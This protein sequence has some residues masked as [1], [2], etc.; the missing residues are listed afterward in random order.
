MIGKKMALALLDALA[1]VGGVYAYRRQK[2][3]MP[4][5]TDKMRTLIVSAF[6]KT[7]TMQYMNAATHRNHSRNAAH[8][9]VP[10]IAT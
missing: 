6:W 1:G 10:I 8:M 5:K 7:L 3:R 4:K 9:S 2:K